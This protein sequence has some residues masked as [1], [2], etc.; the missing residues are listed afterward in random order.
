MRVDYLVKYSSNSTSS[1]IR[2][3]TAR[4]Q[5]IIQL[6][7]CAGGSLEFTV[8]ATVGKK[9]AERKCNPA[10]HNPPGVYFIGQYLTFERSLN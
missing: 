3:I 9:N 8:C 10:E 1:F 7:Q 5:R 6:N 4:K 2:G